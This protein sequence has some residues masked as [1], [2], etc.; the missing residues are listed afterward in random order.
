MQSYNN[1]LTIVIPAYN[2]EKSLIIF[3]PEIIK[4]CMESGSKL[5]VVNDGSTDNTLEVLNKL[6]NNLNN[7]QIKIINHKLN[8]GYG[9]AIKSGIEAADSGE[10]IEV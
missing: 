10:I 5:I 8:K 2:E 6:N 7:Q 1:L 4:F 3:L 9:G